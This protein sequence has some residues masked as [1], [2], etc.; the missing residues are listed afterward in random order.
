MTSLPTWRQRI[1]AVLEWN[2]VDK[3]QILLAMLI[4]IYSQYLLWSLYTLGR[5]DRERLVNVP[6]LES[7]VMIEAG[8]IAGTVLLMLFGLAIRRRH[9]ELV[10]FQHVCA[11]FY[12]V[13]LVTCGYF[14][15]TMTFASGVV[16]LGAAVCG[17]I[18][19]DRQVVW[20]AALT[21]AALLIGLSYA[22]TLGHLPYAPALLP[23]DDP[24]SAM[25]HLNSALGFAAPHLVLIFLLADQTITFWRKRENTIREISRSDALTGLSNRRAIM[26]LLDKEVARTLRHGPPLAVVILDL[27]H[28]KRINDTWGHPTGD[29]VLQQAAQVLKKSIRTCDA[30]GRYGG[31]EFMLLLPDTPLDGAAVLVERCRKALADAVI[32]ADSGDIVHISGSFGLA[33]NEQCRKFS[34]EMLIKAADDALYRAKAGGRNRV[35][36]VALPAED[37]AA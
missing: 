24:A 5:A 1:A 22:S 15:G 4:P 32:T 25:F 16:L 17:F 12:A 9:P 26:E 19:L 27:D 18:V 2:P 10:L 33:S 36:A 34:A 23:P 28:F 6:V 3:G 35:E 37:V 13:T 31:E 7:L 21:A 14:I 20:L 29:R 30:V 11:L 8:F